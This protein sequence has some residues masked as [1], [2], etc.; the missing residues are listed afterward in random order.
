MKQ[1]LV[2][3]SG[4]STL[5]YQLIY[6]DTEQVLANGFVRRIGESTDCD[7]GETRHE[8]GKIRHDL[9]DKASDHVEAIK[10][11]LSYFEQFGPKLDL[12]AVGHRVVHGGDQFSHATL[13]DCKVKQAISELSTLAPLHNPPALK[14]I[15]VA[16]KA[17]GEIP[18]VAVFDTAFHQTLPEK[19]YIY[20]IDESIAKKH[21]IRK[22]GFHGTSYEYVSGKVAEILKKPLKNLNMI[23]LHLGSGASIAAIKN[24]KSF[25][26][27][28]GMTPL[29][30]LIMNTRSGDIDPAVVTHLVR[31]EKM[32]YDSIDDFLNKKSGFY[33]LNDG[34]IDMRDIMELYDS[35]DIKAR[36]AVD[37]YM[38]RIHHYIGAY[39]VGLGR[40]D[41]IVFTAGVG[42]NN[43]PARREIMK[44]LEEP[45]GAKID[46]NLNMEDGGFVIGSRDISARDSKIPVLVV[47]TNEELSIA[48]QTADVARQARG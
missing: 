12:F 27:S 34:S 47:Q 9:T 19:N 20:A 48:Q 38:A 29:A 42:E 15:E 3:N 16:E 7:N 33:G 21:K 45:L 35:G 18:H 14:G 6:I 25:N 36:R 2:L 31:Q 23:I 8:V 40:V 44:G 1:V 22:Y 13:I 39:F 41:A 43:G 5:K 24:G 32:S 17:F 4:S 46:D 37:A 28:M 11:I 30:G 10:L 26:T